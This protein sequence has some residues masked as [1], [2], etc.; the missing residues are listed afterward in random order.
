MTK[1]VIVQHSFGEPG[2]GGPITALGRILNSRLA[3]DY[4]FP[5]IHQTQ[6][7]GFVDSRR[8]RDWARVLRSLRPDLV[9]VRGLGNE[10]FHAAAAARLAGCPRILVSIHGTVR[11][12]VA[13]RGRWRRLVLSRLVE[14][15]TLEVATHIATVCQHAADRDFVRRHESKIVGVVPN[16]VPTGP[17]D[18]AV[19]REMRARLG[20]AD[21]DLV[22]VMVGRLTMEKGHGVLA[23]A[24]RSDPVTA[25]GLRLLIVGDGP[26][27]EQIQRV[28]GAVPALRVSYLGRRH[29]VGR[30]LQAADLFVFPTLHENL[31]NALLEAMASGLPVVATEVGGNVE[32]LEHGGGV[33]VPPAD[34]AALR[35]ALRRMLASGVDRQALGRSARTTVE[36]HYSCHRM[37]EGWGQVYETILG[38]GR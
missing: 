37:V 15:L 31:S 12:L 27:R 22:G 38:G 8:I 26:D 17:M 3:D 36:R 32:V 10:G 19:R 14:P 35:A 5:R 11:D 29:D 4:A 6:T 28:Y 25:A 9:H 16:G 33:L 2:T 18:P 1:P 23:D 7:T 24:L 21:G 13:Q 34:P 20:L 30:I